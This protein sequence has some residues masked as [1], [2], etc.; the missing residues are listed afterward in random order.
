M[1][2][3][4]MEMASGVMQLLTNILVY[5]TYLK[6]PRGSTVKK[7]SIQGIPNQSASPI[8]LHL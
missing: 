5:Q 8:E 3:C 6:V 1:A 4:S 7:H 2:H